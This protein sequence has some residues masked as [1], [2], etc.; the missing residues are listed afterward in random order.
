MNRTISRSKELI[1][2]L[3]KPQETPSKAIL[4]A[5]SYTLGVYLGLRIARSNI[6]LSDGQILAIAAI[7]STMTYVWPFVTIPCAIGYAAYEKV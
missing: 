3:F 4:G 7:A 6:D 5:T 2:K 1:F